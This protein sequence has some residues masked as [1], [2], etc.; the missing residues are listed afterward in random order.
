MNLMSAEGNE[1]GVCGHVCICD[2]QV[3]KMD[4]WT[5]NT[6][7]WIYQNVQSK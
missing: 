1:T 3:G 5:E 6:V 2:V 7:H 4:L